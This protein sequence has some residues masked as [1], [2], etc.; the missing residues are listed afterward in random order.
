RN[1]KTTWDEDVFSTEDIREMSVQAIAA[2]MEQKVKKGQLKKSDKMK[3][4]KSNAKTSIVVPNPK[5]KD[6]NFCITVQGNTSVFPGSINPLAKNIRPG[7]VC[8]P[9]VDASDE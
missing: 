1:V 2:V 4:P 9:E 3:L 5:V 6:Q 8:S 7:Q